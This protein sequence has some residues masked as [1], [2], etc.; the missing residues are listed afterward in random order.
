MKQQEHNTSAARA[1]LKL[2]VMTRGM[3]L[4]LR[5]AS[6]AGLTFLFLLLRLKLGHAPNYPFLLFLPAVALSAVLFNRGSGITATMLSAFLVWWFFM[7]DPETS[8]QRLENRFALATF[9]AVGILLSAF[10]E[11]MHALI[12]RLTSAHEEALAMNARLVASEQEKDLML[13]ELAHR[14]KNDLQTLNSLLRL[15]AR[16]IE[17]GNAKSAL[18]AAADRTNVVA[19]MHDRLRRRNRAPVI[20]LARFLEDI[21]DDIRKA[22]FEMRPIGLRTYLT[23]VIVDARRA[24][25]VGLILN[26]LVTN[27]LKYAFPDDRAGTITVRLG[28]NESMIE[29]SVSDNGVGIDSSAPRGTGVGQ[30]L[31]RAL[32]QQLDG[33]FSTDSAPGTGTTCRFAIP[34]AEET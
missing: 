23:P 7:Q 21:C 27:A 12:V 19:R 11:V 29:L 34:L 16:S 28:C 10:I 31:V 25:S 14:T 5:H 20:D 32:T 33:V 18:M 2:A 13:E 17:E 26:E 3:P 9:V 22:H 8:A 1:L 15:Q 30:R 6:A 4:L 24:A